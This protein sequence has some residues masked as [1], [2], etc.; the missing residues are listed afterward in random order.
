MGENSL[1][2]S[3]Y[4]LEIK[5]LLSPTEIEDGNP[6]EFKFFGFSPAVTAGTYYYLRKFYKV[7]EMENSVNSTC[8]AFDFAYKKNTYSYLTQKQ[9]AYYEMGVS[10]ETVWFILIFVISRKN[11]PSIVAQLFYFSISAIKT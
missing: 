11:I 1:Y 9:F 8:P 3:R 10:G 6:E 2:N 5:S 7:L 4:Q